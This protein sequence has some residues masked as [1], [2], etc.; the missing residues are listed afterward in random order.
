MKLR[1]RFWEYVWR[2]GR[3]LQRRAAK[4][5]GKTDNPVWEQGSRYRW[6]RTRDGYVR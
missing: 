4:A 5:L 3:A 2:L 6:R 1:L